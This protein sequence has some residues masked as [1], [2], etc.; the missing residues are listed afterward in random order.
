MPND[1]LAA[2]LD[3]SLSQL[4]INTLRFLAVDAVQRANSGH[5]GM[6]M[7]AAPMAYAVWHRHLVVD[8][9]KTD[10]PNRDRFI[11][12]AGHGSMLLYGLL[13]LSGFDLS[14]DDI[15]DFRQWGSRTPGH[16]EN[17]HTSGVETTTGPLGQGFANGIG[18]AIAETF[19]AAHFNRPGFD[20]VDHQTMAIVSDGDLME[21]ISHEAASW[22]GHLGLGKLTYLYDDNKITI[23]GSTD[24]SFTE[25]VTGRFEAYG[26][27]VLDIEDGNDV[28]AI[29]EAINE[30]RAETGKPTLIRVHTII[31]Y[32]SPNKA[33]TAA[34]HGSPLGAQ[35]IELT[36]EG[37]NWPLEPT[38]HVPDDARE[39]MGE[40]ATRGQE[41]REAWEEMMRDYK[42]EFPDLAEQWERWNRGDL[43]ENL[44][45]LMPAFEEGSSI[46][47]RSANG[48]VLAA[49]DLDLPN[50][51]GGSADLTGSNKTD[52][53]GR[54]D[55]QRD[56]PSGS[57]FYFGV[58]EHAMASIC[59]G[60][61]LHGGLRT[62]CGTFLIFSDYMRPA[63][64]LSAL[65][66]Q[67][68][69]YV[70]THDS[71]GLGEDGP[72]HQPIE[73]FM[74]LRAI[75]NCTFIRP[76][77]GP[78]TAGAWIAALENKTGPTLLGLSRQ[79][80]PTMNSNVS[81]VVAN[82]K[83]GAYIIRDSEGAPDAIIIATGS[84]VEV[85]VRAATQLA[86][87]GLNVRVVSMPSWEIFEQQEASYRESVL[88]PSVTVRVSVEAGITMGWERYVG[89]TGRSIGL[90]HFG[91]SA[92]AET[93]FEHFGITPENVASAVRSQLD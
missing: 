59:N 90:D 48:K 74:T 30:A 86:Q 49:L 56:N 50:L 52:I 69:T 64:R 16:P 7:G 14:I 57:Y 36:K 61:Q 37:L 77:D 12:S 79:N 54:R 73:H 34:S 62:Y 58:R 10:W 85:G 2:T 67:P 25:D 47:T 89:P 19:L 78:E 55:F 31:G 46:A 17:F 81:D 72:T 63:I 53:P 92:P 66:G 5:P 23:D 42:A 51:I 13:H 28:E 1:A 84:E 75:P 82:V 4:S 60:M 65:M 29:D 8:P 32:G 70:F 40:I 20:V 3:I 38:F 68:V 88:P 15:K 83:M 27:Q 21:G 33:G 35:E 80:L 91:A 44:T 9:S 43:P 45:S 71:I 87:E 93:L 76:C 18:M 41:K 6:P 24:L 22:A 26:W 11:L 39:H